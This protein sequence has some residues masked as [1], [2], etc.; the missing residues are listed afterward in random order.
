MAHAARTDWAMLFG[1][2]FLLIIGSG[3]FYMDNYIFDKGNS[4]S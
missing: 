4:K 3:K 1:S 2:I